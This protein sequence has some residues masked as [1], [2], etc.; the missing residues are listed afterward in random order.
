MGEAAIRPRY[1][2]I[3]G[4]AGCA[5]YSMLVLPVPCIGE[6]DLGDPALQTQL[7]VQTPL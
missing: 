5:D 1:A 7:K 4:H 3:Y 6:I 2:E